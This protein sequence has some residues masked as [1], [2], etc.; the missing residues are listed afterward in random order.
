SPSRSR[1]GPAIRTRSRTPRASSTAAPLPDGP[2]VK[3]RPSGRRPMLTLRRSRLAALFIMFGVAGVAALAR[4]DNPPEEV[5]TAVDHPFDVDNLRLDLD[6]DLAHKTIE[7]RAT[8]RVKAR[9]A[10]TRVRL[11]GVALQV[12]KV[13][14]ATGAKVP[15]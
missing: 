8:L 14:V 10:I 3:S 13:L 12:S 9:R 5:K 4:A 11:D 7:G 6:V 1:S 15:A 2:R